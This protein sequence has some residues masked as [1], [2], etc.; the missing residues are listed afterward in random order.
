MTER[1]LVL[2]ISGGSCLELSLHFIKKLPLDIK[3][4]VVPS[5]NAYALCRAEK[6]QDLKWLI[7]SLRTHNLE[8]Q[9]SLGSP[10]ASGSFLF[11]S[12]L[13]LPTSSNTLSRIAS[14]IQDNLLTRIAAICLK[15][16]RS[17]ILGIREMPLNAI[18]LENMAKLS[19]LGVCIAPPIVGYYSDVIDLE[20]LHNFLVGKYFDLLKI[21]HNFFRRWEGVR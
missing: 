10:L 14:G 9:D 19:S 20:S 6:K 1:I 18:L 17:L 3:L 4:F 15:E 21:P 13:I 8:I 11:E 12:C 7:G 2:G 16:K 5:K